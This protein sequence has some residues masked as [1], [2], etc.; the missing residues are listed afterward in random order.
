MATEVTMRR[1]SASDLQVGGRIPG[2]NNK[3]FFGVLN[4]KDVAAKGTF[5]SG[6]HRAREEATLLSGLEHD[7]I[8]K[9]YGYCE[10][11]GVAYVVLERALGPVSVDKLSRQFPGRRNQRRRALEVINICLQ[12]AAG[13]GYL[14]SKGIIHRDIK[15]RNILAFVGGVFKICD[16]DIAKRLTGGADDTQ[17]TGRF[18]CE[19][20]SPEAIMKNPVSKASDMYSFGATMCELFTGAGPWGMKSPFDINDSVKEGKSADG[21]HNVWPKVVPPS[22]REMVKALLQYSSDREISIE[23]VMEVLNAA[24]AELIGMPED[25]EAHSW[26]TMGNTEKL[27]PGWLNR[28]NTPS[29]AEGIRSLSQLTLPAERNDVK[30]RAA[31]WKGTIEK[32]LKDHD[33]HDCA[34][35]CALH[36]YTTESDVCYVVNAVLSKPDSTQ[37]MLDCIGPYA[38][39]L[40]NA[41]QKLGTPYENL[42]YRVVFADDTTALH[43]SFLDPRTYFLP[44]SKLRV[45]QFCSFAKSF[46]AI[47]HLHDDTRQKI[48]FH[49]PMLT[50]HDIMRLSAQGIKEKEVMVLPPSFF[51]VIRA[52]RSDALTLTVDINH[53]ANLSDGKRYLLPTATVDSHAAVRDETLISSVSSPPPTVH[54]VAEFLQKLRSEGTDVAMKINIPTNI[55]DASWGELL[56]VVFAAVERNEV[57]TVEALVGLHRSRLGTLDGPEGLLDVCNGEGWSPLCVAARSGSLEMVRSL[58]ALGADLSFIGSPTRGAAIQVAVEHGH[59]KLL[60]QLVAWKPDLLLYH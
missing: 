35:Q 45:F 20:A 2:T 17:G 32:S 54:I 23:H 55:A 13:L 8:V 18:T 49:C 51:T 28:F 37:D 39:R 21:S 6:F 7:H 16:L 47:K 60:Q 58:Y 59:V 34:L 42:G 25:E 12:V 41:V 9:L 10:K 56:P 1:V 3:V 44:G 53:H 48:V 36:S 38:H 19:Y 5:D 57:P 14:H 52:Y 30:K 33:G 27:S 24:K 22:I 26:M 4:G 43:S 40:F 31:T 46:D 15:P 29:I 50:G 11:D